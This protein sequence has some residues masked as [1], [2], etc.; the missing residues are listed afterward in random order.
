[1]LSGYERNAQA[2][3]AYAYE[4]DETGQTVPAAACRAG[5][6]SRTAALMDLRL[7]SL[8]LARAIQGRQSLG[9]GN[10]GRI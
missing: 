5:K 4:T 2:F 9:F 8:P 10:G 6:A 3:K 7:P 1:M